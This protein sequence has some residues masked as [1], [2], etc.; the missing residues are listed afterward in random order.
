[1]NV[2]FHDKRFYWIKNRFAFERPPPAMDNESAFARFIKHNMGVIG[3]TNEQKTGRPYN[4]H[5]CLFRAY[6]RHKL[7]DDASSYQLK[8]KTKEVFCDY[9]RNNHAAGE[10]LAQNPS[11]Y[12]GFDLNQDLVKFEDFFKVK[13]TLYG[14]DK[15]PDSDEVFCTLECRSIQKEYD[16]ELDL[17][18]W[19]HHLSYIKNFHL[20]VK[21]VK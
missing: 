9:I 13:V 18:L 6:A 2:V 8:Q 10:L 16:D 14:L 21:T 20:F 1:M 15:D 11:T 4:D 17:V 19:E 12:Q 7:G 5:L 3:L